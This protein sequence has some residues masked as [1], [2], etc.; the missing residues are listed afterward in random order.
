MTDTQKRIVKTRVECLLSPI[1]T[2]IRDWK[3][4]T[5]ELMD[6]VVSDIECSADWSE[7]GADEGC[8]DDIDIALA[9]VLKAK[10]IDY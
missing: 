5:E 7:L 1:F 3:E 10:I 6:D 4:V 9:R 8:I 2:D